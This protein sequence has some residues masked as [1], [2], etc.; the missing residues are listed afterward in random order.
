MFGT[1]YGHRDSTVTIYYTH[2]LQ[3][4]QYCNN[5]EHNVQDSI[6]MQD[7]VRR[8][9]CT[10]T[11]SYGQSDRLSADMDHIQVAQH[12]VIMEKT[13]LLLSVFITS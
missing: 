11:G 6:L 13:I 9:L 3:P 8:S 2:L 4:I 5:Y 12:Q 7:F 10:E 1:H